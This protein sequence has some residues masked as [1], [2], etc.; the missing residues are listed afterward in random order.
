MKNIIPGYFLFTVLGYLS[1][2]ILFGNV[3]SRFLKGIDLTAVSDDGN[4][5]TFN[6]F[7]YGGALC[8]I[9]TL[10][11]DLLK[12]Y[13]PVTA[14]RNLLGSGFLLFAFVMAAPVFGHAFSV[15]NHGDGGKAI[16]VSFGVLLG[17]L[18]K[19][20]PLVALAGFY[21]FFSLVIRLT[22][23]AKRSIYAFLGFLLTCVLFEKQRSVIWGCIMLATTVIYKHCVPFFYHNT[24]I[25]I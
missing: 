19:A 1:G 9:L 8:G 18:P 14:C 24:R 15:F 4:P 20:F 7:R 25:D 13:L 17:L 12:G 2:S 21:L 10:L 23:H 5:G 22:P 16:A 3:F 11:A 6:A